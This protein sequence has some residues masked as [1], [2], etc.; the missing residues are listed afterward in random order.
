M[1]GIAD[2]FTIHIPHSFSIL[3]WNRSQFSARLQRVSRI[4][5]WPS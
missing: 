4:L 2:Y 1:Y 5:R 3:C